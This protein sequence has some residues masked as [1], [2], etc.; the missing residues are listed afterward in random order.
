MVTPK[1]IPKREIPKRESAPFDQQLLKWLKH[2][3]ILSK[4]CPCQTIGQFF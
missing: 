1:L 2:A 4:N 3:L